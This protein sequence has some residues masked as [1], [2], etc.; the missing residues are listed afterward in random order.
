[1]CTLGIC[2]SERLSASGRLLLVGSDQLRLRQQIPVHR[3]VEF[4]LGL[5]VGG[6]GR[7]RSGGGATY[8]ARCESCRVQVRGVR[9]LIRCV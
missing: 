6:F 4:H 7:L 1:V 5:Q 3:A 9:T 2:T 8:T